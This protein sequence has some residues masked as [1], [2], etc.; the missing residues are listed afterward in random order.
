MAMTLRLSTEQDAALTQIAEQLHI[1]KQQA[2]TMAVEKFIEQ[3]DQQAIVR[4]AFDLVKERDAELLR[5][6]EDA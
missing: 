3:N 2:V 1:S 5:R 6:L 4:R